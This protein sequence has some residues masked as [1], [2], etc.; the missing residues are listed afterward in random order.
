MFKYNLYL[1][2]KDEEEVLG[3]LIENIS[4]LA[5]TTKAQYSYYATYHGNG[6]KWIMDTADVSDVSLQHDLITH[7]RI[8]YKEDAMLC[9]LRFGGKIV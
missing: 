3:W 7:I 9:A 1:G 4:P 8:R 2:D 5:M 6:D